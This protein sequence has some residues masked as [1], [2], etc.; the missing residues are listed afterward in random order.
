MT[1]SQHTGGKSLTDLNLDSICDEFEQSWKEQHPKTIESFADRQSGTSSRSRVIAALLEIELEYVL[2]SRTPQEDDYLRRFPEEPECVHGAFEKFRQRFPDKFAGT[3]PES[4]VETVAGPQRGGKSEFPLPHDFGDRYTLTECLGSGGMGEV[5]RAFDKK[6]HKEVALKIPKFDSE[7]PNQVE[8]FIGEARAAAKVEHPGICQV[9]DIADVDGRLFITMQLIEG[10]SLEKLLNE[11]REFTVRQSVALIRKVAEAMSVAHQKKVIHRDIKPANIML[12]PRGDAIV[13]DFGLALNEMQSGERLTHRGDFL[14]T[15]AYMPIEQARGDL[16]RIDQRTDVYSLTAVLFR[17]L[18][19]KTPYQGK[20][21]VIA[22]Q[23][24]HAEKHPE[25]RPSL[26]TLRPDLD[27][28]LLLVVDRGMAFQPQER[29]ASMQEMAVGLREYQRQLVDRD[30]EQSG[31]SGN[32]AGIRNEAEIETLVPGRR[33][34]VQSQRRRQRYIPAACL[35]PLLCLLAAVFF[36]RTEYG[37]LRIEVSD[38]RLQVLVDGNTISVA[39]ADRTLQLKAGPDKKL[40]IKSDELQFEV[41]KEFSLS[42]SDGEKR[43]HVVLLEDGRPELREGQFQPGMANKKSESRHYATAPASATSTG[44]RGWPVDA[45]APANFPFDA[46]QARA[47]QEAWAKY[48]GVMVEFENQIGMKFRLIPPGE[49]LMGSTPEEI[50]AALKAVGTNPIWRDRI[51]S[52]GPRHRVLLTQPIYFGVTE[53]TQS[54]YEKVVGN[55]PSHFSATGAG[56]EAVTEIL[57]TGNHPVDNVSWHDAVDFCQKLSQL[58]HLRPPN[59]FSGNNIGQI[60]V[61]GYGLPTE[62]E[63]EFACRGGTTSLFWIGDDDNKLVEA[64]WFTDNS[65]GRPHRVGTLRANPFGLSDMHGNVWEWVQDTWDPEYYSTFQ[66]DTA[67]DPNPKSDADSSRICR[68]GRWA[69]RPTQCRSSS[70]DAID[71]RR[72]SADVGFRVVLLVEWPQLGNRR[73]DK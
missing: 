70:R 44:W 42:K 36:V 10:K 62:A 24:M 6:L 48:L 12:T 1:E 37:T 13:V 46:D 29:Y 56:K 20:P 63:W 54:Q 5:Y 18:A 41:E 73:S 55:N 71:P 61:R 59:L 14:G 43:L 30:K 57:D 51:R 58:E 39:D 66:I 72:G 21:V 53:V 38:P 23:I 7:D 25:A 4:D 52:E 16:P 68:G 26:R 2:R 35:L 3:H 65:E 9:Y 27:E 32:P 8:R 31:N 33:L 50:V 45:P 19:G 67:I 28:Q 17:L 64:C 22:A 34:A 47:H 15:A 11:G 69:N 49:F 40:I 60:E